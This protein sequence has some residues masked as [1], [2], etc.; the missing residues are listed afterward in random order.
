MDNP[1]DRLGRDIKKKITTT[2]IG[3]LDSVEKR[4]G[5]LWGNHKNSD[6]EFTQQENRFY[7]IWLQVRE[8]ILDRGNAQIG[9][10]LSNLDAYQIEDKRY[11]I[12]FINRR[13]DERTDF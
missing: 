13:Q 4:L 2:M 3:A 7:E 11:N 10:M 6:E 1:K 9:A 5:K 12:T 8:E